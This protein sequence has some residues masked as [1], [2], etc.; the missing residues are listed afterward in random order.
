MNTGTN[1][2]ELFYSA[3]GNDIDTLEK[4][5]EDY[6]V[7]SVARFLLLYHY[8]KNNLPGFEKLAKQTGVYL[9]NPY[10]IQYQLLQTDEI[11]EESTSTDN[12]TISIS[13]EENEMDESVAYRGDESKITDSSFNREI[14]TEEDQESSDNI[15]TIDNKEHEI[16]LNE[17]EEKNEPSEPIENI[18]PEIQE[19]PIVLEIKK[20]DEKASQ[21]AAPNTDVPV[22]EKEMD[23]PDTEIPVN[24]ESDFQEQKPGAEFPVSENNEDISLSF[25]PLHTIDYFASQGIK[26]TEE[27]LE[28]DQL[29]KQVKSFTAWLKS[30]KRLHPGQVPEQNEVIEKIIQ[31]SAEAS[32]QN[33]NVLT[34]VMAEVLIKQ[35]KEEKAIEMYQKLSLIN[36]SKSAYFAAKIESLKTS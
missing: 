22:V 36:P 21:Y 35:G 23:L 9:N 25:E 20:E 34:E 27:A 14:I 10:W 1:Y 24:K 13:H 16:G 29:G 11:A 18:E 26:I 17:S 3:S 7:S 6:P 30:M 32:N 33:A 4:N 8:Q 12:S 31:S 15:T 2:T 19:E 28:N 5:V